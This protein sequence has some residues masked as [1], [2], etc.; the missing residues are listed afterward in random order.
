MRSDHYVVDKGIQVV[1]LNPHKSTVSS[2]KY[3]QANSLPVELVSSHCL[4]VRRP[5]NARDID[6]SARPPCQ[7]PSDSLLEHS[8]MKTWTT[9]HPSI[10]RRNLTFYLHNPF[11]SPTLPIRLTMI[12]LQ[13]TMTYTFA[14]ALG[15]PVKRPTHR[16]P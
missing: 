15:P 14:P 5:S 16:E 7:S 6:R 9:P 1:F 2:V 12:P 4:W 3:I 8:G 13:S 10:T 11:R